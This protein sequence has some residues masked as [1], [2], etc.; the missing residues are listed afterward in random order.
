MQYTYARCASVFRKVGEFNY[1]E[2]IYYSVL[3]DEV[4]MNLLKDIT[5]FPDVI[6]D[7]AEK[8]EPFMISRFAVSV[9]Q[10]FNKF[11]HDCQIN[12]EDEKVKAARLKVVSATMNVIKS[13]LDL[14][15]ME[16]PEQM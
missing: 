16:C 8:Y 13:A 7:A 12:V 14:L 11:Y 3:T 4:T 1:N 15:G 6:K 9:A 2:E 5:R 10:H